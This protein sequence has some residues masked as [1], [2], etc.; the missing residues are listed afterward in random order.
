MSEPRAIDV[1]IWTR[2]ARTYRGLIVP[3]GFVLLLGV[4]LV[5]LPPFL[6]D[7]LISLNISLSVIV[8]L[9][10]IYLNRA[11][12][13]SVFP[14]LLLGTTLFR[15]VLNIAST[16]LILTADAASPQEAM[17]VAGHVISAF[18]SFVAGDSLFVGVVLFLIIMIVQFIVVTKGAGRISE[19][20]ARF[21]LD[22]MP[23]K[24]MAIDSDLS[25]GLIDEAEAR[26]RRDEVSREADFFGAMDGASKF[27]K[28]DTIAGMII[29]VINIVGGFAVGAIERGWP[30]AQTAQVFTKLTIGDGLTSQIP[31]FVIA[32]ASALIVTRSGSKEDL[33]EEMTGQIISQPRGLVITAI[34]LALLAFT[35]LPTIPLVGTA[36]G[37]GAIAFGLR[38]AA[39]LAQSRQNEQRE[40][41]DA[42]PDAPP[43]ESLLKV[44]VLELEVGYGLV[45]LID[46]NQ[47]GTLLDRI[48]A[49]RRQLAVETGLVMPPVR[50]RDNMQL[51]PGDYRIKIRGN[52]VAS[53]E[54]QPE[55]L[56]AM[57]SGI[58]LGRI[59]GLSTREPAFG[60]PAWWIDPSQ[61]SRAE[62]L[63]YTVVDPT[64][65][66][67]T[68]ITEI[69]RR[70][71]D[72]LLTR[73]EVQNLLE[74]LKQ[75]TPKLVDDTVP[76]VIKVGELQ[77]VLQRLLRERIPIRDL[78]SV[79][80]VLADW[81][82]RTKDVDVLVEYVRNG[83]KRTICQSSAVPGDNGKLRLVCVT[84]D[85]ALEDVIESYV[86]R[87]GGVTTVNMPSRVA[88]DIGSRIARAV[89]AGATS[90]GV[91]PVVIASP[92]VRA[93][94][95]DVIE[96]FT[97]T[98]PVLGYNEVLSGVEIESVQLVGAESLSTAA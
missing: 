51:R 2:R 97:P 16:R 53:G 15:L 87:S 26:K 88:H 30:A 76:G 80:E 89:E 79:L 49:V 31:S 72:E 74:G 47:G 37:L 4:L 40:E 58:C 9:T 96:P 29:T 77:K 57:D 56:M 61:Q 83:L 75:R 42:A 82:T 17:N 18:G 67:A 7:V 54:L 21:T 25:A 33:G 68:H 10:T 22:A 44:D 35:P 34:F 3:L 19:V 24:Q 20:A 85:P 63:N 73:E 39:R 59:E 64:S 46:V 52:A 1:G 60:L 69:V 84:I 50:I 78:E 48:S 11:L 92:R 36:L 70:H 98:T 38:R 27:V 66:L 94:V 43:V 12:D 55:L 62:A 14:S 65:V 13:F 86:D 91:A 93:V 41:Q 5:P 28:G 23:G 95:R 81:A 6:L 71:A 45:S 32:I 8:L 90:T